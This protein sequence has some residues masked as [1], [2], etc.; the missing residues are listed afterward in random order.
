MG[1]ITRETPA[2]RSAEK[3]ASTPARRKPP[4]KV[5]GNLAVRLA[6]YNH[7]AN[8]NSENELFLAIWSLLPEFMSIFV[9]EMRFGTF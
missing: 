6:V 9:A 1:T 3:S 2:K 7:Q 5:S 4:E 8:E